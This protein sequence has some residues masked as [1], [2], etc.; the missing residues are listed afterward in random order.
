MLKQ[1]RILKEP[2]IVLDK[3]Q[4]IAFEVSNTLNQ[5]YVDICIQFDD[6]L[7]NASYDTPHQGPASLT[8]YN[9]AIDQIKIMYFTDTTPHQQVSL[10]QL[11]NDLK[12][13]KVEVKKEYYN[14]HEVYISAQIDRVQTP[15]FISFEIPH[16]GEVHYHYQ[17]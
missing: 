7:I 15:L 9:V 16:R 8:I 14:H 3:A 13:L 1:I 4:I 6:A 11:K 12:Q 5:G 2:K 17:K 10:A